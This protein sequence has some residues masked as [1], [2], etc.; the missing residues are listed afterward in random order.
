MPPIPGA[1]ADNVFTLRNVEDIE[2]IRTAA[3]AASDVVVAGGGFIGLEVA[4]NLRLAGKNVSLVE[5]QSQ[6]LPRL[7]AD[8]VQLLHRELHE[9]GVNLVLSDAI[10]GIDADGVSLQSGNRIA[11]QA[12]ILAVGVRPETTLAA[13]AGLEIGETGGIKVNHNFQTSDPD[14][15]AVGDAVELGHQI[16]GAATMLAL[17]G[18]AQRAARKAADH[19]FGRTV[20]R[21]GVLGSSVVQVFGLTAASTGLTEQ[22][23]RASGREFDSIYFIGNDRVGLMP[24]ATPVHLKLHFD[25]TT[26]QVL[27]AQAVAKAGAEKRIDVIATL[28]RMNGTLE[29]MADL[30]LCYAPSYATAKDVVNMAALVALNK[31][32]GDVPSVNA[33]ELRSLVEQ[34]AYIIDVR[35][36]GEWDAGH[37]KAAVNVPYSKFREHLAEIPKDQPVYL[38]CRIG[39]RSYFM[40]R[41]L[42]GLGWDNVVNVNGAF[43]ALSNIEYF[44]DM[45]TGREP[46]VDKYNFR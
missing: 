28:I 37:I 15:Y 16:T 5:M 34:G 43:L 38:H 36:Q 21:N 20:R 11:A 26:G 25:L 12:V 9:Q 31:L 40:A 17:A 19:T 41:E 44:Q 1:D 42:I 2:A 33:A 30:E 46:I 32:Q 10:A 13:A 6:V 8:I 14:I 4:E 3:D 22:E 29:D 27:G 35:E 7:D 24:G 23:C 45:S 18:P 39:Q